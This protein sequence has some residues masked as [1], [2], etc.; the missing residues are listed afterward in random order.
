M[1]LSDKLMTYLQKLRA[2]SRR[3]QKNRI[4]TS[5]G[6]KDLVMSMVEVV[7]SMFIKQSVLSGILACSRDIRFKF[8]SSYT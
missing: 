6:Q 8:I 4:P 3:V 1:T 2:L 5:I 7:A